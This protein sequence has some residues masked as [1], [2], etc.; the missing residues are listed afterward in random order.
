MYNERR[1]TK[2]SDRRI[3]SLFLDEPPITEAD[4]LGIRLNLEALRPTQDRA[5]TSLGLNGDFSRFLEYV[6]DTMVERQFPQLTGDE[7]QEHWANRKKQTKDRIKSDIKKKYIPR[8]ET[9]LKL[10]L[11]SVV[12]KFSIE[13]KFAELRWCASKAA[14]VTGLR[15]DVLVTV[16]DPD[17]LRMFGL[18]DSA[19]Q[20][21]WGKLKASL[22]DNLHESAAN[23]INAVEYAASSAL[24]SM[25]TDND[26][27]VLA[28]DRNVY[29]VIVTRHY[30]YFDG[31]RTMHVYFIPM[32]KDKLD[33]P[34][35][36]ALT[37]LRLATRFRMMFLED[38]SPLSPTA[39]ALNQRNPDVYIGK[40]KQFTRETLYTKG[41]SHN[42]Q[43]DDPQTFVSSLGEDGRPTTSSVAKLYDEWRSETEK[44]LSSAAKVN[45][46]G[47]DFNR[48]SK[49]WG[50]ALSDYIDFVA[51]INQDIGARAAE[52]LKAWF[53]SFQR[54]SNP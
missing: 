37:L 52:H 50:I 16:S 39:F 48:F 28:D 47:F 35:S 10:A 19:D 24:S 7:T 49:V 27:L 2:K 43:L 31:S 46:T 17:L 38:S 51:P 26:Q 53:S 5:T 12:A 33:G 8:L 13:Q 29:R 9:E 36:R 3:I 22:I 6:S 30:A 20:V 44:V 25:P 42:H 34:G 1:E 32:L 54:N 14:P 41:Q 40:V 45:A 15:E 11:T 4:I 18:F 21:T 23:F